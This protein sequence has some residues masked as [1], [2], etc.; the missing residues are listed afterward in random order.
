MRA[1]SDEEANGE[2]IEQGAQGPH[3]QHKDL[4][5][6]VEGPVRALKKQM[7]NI[8]LSRLPTVSTPS[9]RI[10]AYLRKV[11]CVPCLI[12][13]QMENILSRMPRVPTPSDRI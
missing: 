11:L 13:K 8:L 10:L 9:I 1:L 12:K 3:T 7:E 5:I 2:Y 4:G 6:P